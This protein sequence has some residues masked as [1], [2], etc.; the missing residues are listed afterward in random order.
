[1]KKHELFLVLVLTLLPL[2]LCRRE[3]KESR[4][5]AALPVP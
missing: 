5:K 1:M 4:R 3:K 2:A